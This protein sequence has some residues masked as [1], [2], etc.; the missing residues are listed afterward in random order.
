MAQTAAN[1][2]AGGVVEFKY[3][4]SITAGGVYGGA[5]IVDLGFTTGG[6]KINRQ[7]D[8]LD[9]EVDQFRAVLK[10]RAILTKMTIS[11]N[12]SEGTLETL[13]LCWS[14]SSTSLVSS[15]SY[16]F[17]T[18]SDGTRELDVYFKGPTVGTATHPGGSVPTYRN[19]E[20]PRC[21][22]MADTEINIARGE[23]FS[24]PL[25]L[26]VLMDNTKTPA[27]WG[28]FWES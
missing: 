18:E 13:R 23:Q 16:L 5:G 22:A 26:D 19:Y 2:F 28:E 9:F 7:T 21:V 1:L 12:L 17:L 20:F 15:S 4:G 8:W 6:V 25:N 27:R 10:K 11:T 24:V 14:L 3:G